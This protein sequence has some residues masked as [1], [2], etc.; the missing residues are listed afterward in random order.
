MEKSKKKCIIHFSCDQV[1]IFHAFETN[2]LGFVIVKI[3]A[4]FILLVS[5][6]PNF[7]VAHNFTDS[8]YESFNFVH[9]FI[10]VF[11]TVVIHHTSHPRVGS[12]K[13]F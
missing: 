4:L 5:Q 6:R 10:H 2:K 3:R 12:E 8:V 1:A 13:D 9:K 7:L 11:F